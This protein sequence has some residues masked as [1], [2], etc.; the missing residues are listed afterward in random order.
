M[1]NVPDLFA[2]FK[3]AS[4]RELR[5]TLEI[6]LMETPYR[7]ELFYHYPNKTNPW[8]VVIYLRESGTWKVVSIFPDV[9]EQKEESALRS[10]L[11]FIQGGKAN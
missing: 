6:T 7:V 5:C 4:Y 3:F 9:Q 11:S 8:E 2:D 1:V 10:A